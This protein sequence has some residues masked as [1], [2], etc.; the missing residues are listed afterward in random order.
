MTVPPRVQAV[1]P[2]RNTSASSMQ[3]PPASADATRVIILSPV[4]ARPGAWPRSRWLWTSSGRPRRRARVAGRI[5]PALATKRWSSKTMRIRSGLFCGSIYWVLLVSGRFSV[6]KPLS[7][8]QR[9]TLWLLQGLSQRPSF[10][11][12]GLIIPAL[13]FVPLLTAGVEWETSDLHRQSGRLE[14][15]L[16]TEVPGDVSYTVHVYPEEHPSRIAVEKSYI[17]GELCSETTYE[18]DIEEGPA[19]HESKEDCL[20]R[21]AS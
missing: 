13:P 3:S 16:R 18:Y 15:V 1:P 17:R 7:Q 10:G 12:F 14:L 5:S 20:S 21:N 4:F 2:V 8:I 19:V 9:S 11:G 6:P